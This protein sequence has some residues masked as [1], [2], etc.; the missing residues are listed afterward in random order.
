MSELVTGERLQPCLL[1]RLTDLEPGNKEES[2][3]NR[4]ISM[5]RYFNEVLRDIRWLLG[6]SKHLESENLKE[7]PSAAVSGLNFGIRS[8]SGLSAGS[9]D[10]R[11][12]EREVAEAI[13]AFEPR[14]NPRSLK[15]KFHQELWK[16]SANELTFEI[17]GDLWAYPAPERLLIKTKLDLETGEFSF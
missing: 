17:E 2:R 14:I 7:F 4:V 12:L 3:F 15:V 13:A 5:A 11:E 8:L 16:H 1:D 6:T 9:L 10:V